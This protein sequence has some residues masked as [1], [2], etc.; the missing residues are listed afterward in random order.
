MEV[1]RSSGIS[2]PRTPPPGNKGG[3][4]CHGARCSPAQA[5]ALAGLA[6]AACA[7]GRP[8]RGAQVP[9]L[10]KEALSLS[11]GV[12]RRTAPSQLLVVTPRRIMR[13]DQA[14][15]KLLG[16][17]SEGP[18]RGRALGILL[19]L[20]GAAIQGDRWPTRVSL[21]I[22][23]RAD[24]SLVAQVCDTLRLAGV[25]TIR[26]LVAAGSSEW[27]LIPNV[28]APPPGCDPGPVVAYRGLRWRVTGEKIRRDPTCPSPSTPVVTLHLPGDAPWRA[29]APLAVRAL[30]RRPGSRLAIRAE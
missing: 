1:L 19:R 29:I 26:L 17:F 13:W 12:L 25:L 8:L 16:R 21:A 14:H 6:L 2:G 10:A 4:G 20:A 7:G 15:S 24:S 22:D 11:V 3:N 27:L 18:F 9:L 28:P 23:G 30:A 5:L